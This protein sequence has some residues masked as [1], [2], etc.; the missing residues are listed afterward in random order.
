MSVEMIRRRIARVIEAAEVDVSVVWNV[1]LDPK[2]PAPT[3]CTFCRRGLHDVL[4]PRARL[5]CSGVTQ[6]RCAACVSPVTAS[7]ASYFRTNDLVALEADIVSRDRK[8]AQ[9]RR[10]RK[11]RARR[12]EMRGA[13]L[14]QWQ[15]KPAAAEAVGVE[16]AEAA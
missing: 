12:W 13:A 7:Y 2:K 15:R 16:L 10:I 9:V 14:K 3:E 4:N 5:E 11:R 6:D 8:A 1:P